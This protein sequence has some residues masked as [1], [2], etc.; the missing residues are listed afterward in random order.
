VKLDPKGEAAESVLRKFSE[1]I[2]SSDYQEDEELRKTGLYQ[3]YIEKYATRDI[4]EQLAVDMKN[5]LEGK[6]DKSVVFSKYE[7][8]NLPP[9]ARLAVHDFIYGKGRYMRKHKSFLQEVGRGLQVF[10]N[11]SAGILG[12]SAAY[13]SRQDEKKGRTG[14]WDLDWSSPV[15]AI[16]AVGAGFAHVPTAVKENETFAEKIREI[17][18]PSSWRY[19]Y[20]TPIGIGMS[21]F[22]DPSMYLTFGATAGSK[23][24]A[25]NLLAEQ[26][27]RANAE[28]HALIKAGKYGGDLNKLDEAVTD[29]SIARGY[30][31]DLGD[32][33]DQVRV[34]SG[35][36]KQEIRSTGHYMPTGLAPGEK[37]TALVR[38][39]TKQKLGA[40]LLPTNLKGGRG[41]RFAGMEIPGTA[42]LTEG[43]GGAVSK[44]ATK[45]RV[46]NAIGN[47]LIPAWQARHIQG[48]AI[49]SSVLVEMSRFT[50]MK[51]MAAKNIAEEVRGLHKVSM[52]EKLIDEPYALKMAEDGT[53]TFSEHKGTEMVVA[54][55][56]EERLGL[57]KADVESVTGPLKV[58]RGRINEEAE[59]ALEEAGKY[60]A[61][62]GR[63]ATTWEGIAKHYDDP[64]EALFDFKLRA[65]TEGLTAEYTN[66]ML[67]DTRFAL[68]LADTK[69]ALAKATAERDEAL[70]ALDKLPGQGKEFYVAARAEIHGAYEVA[71]KAAKE[72]VEGGLEQVPV[73]FT[74]YK[75]G[76]KA[77]AVRD[78][79]AQGLREINNPNIQA[80]STR[81][82]FKTLEQLNR[83]QVLWKKYATSPN[84]AFHV[85]NVLGAMWNNALAGVY[86]PLNYVDATALVYRAKKEEAAQLG[87]KFGM[88]GRGVPESTP[89]GKAAL[90]EFQEA[91]TRGATGSTS[92]IASDQTYSEFDREITKE[93]K[94]IG[95]PTAQG[96]LAKSV[97]PPP[98]MSKK[99]F[100][101][102]R[103][104]QSAATA[105]LLPGGIAA[106]IGL[107]LMAPEAAKVGRKW[108]QLM[109]DVVRIAPFQQASK[110]VA[111][112]RA[113]HTFGPIHVDDMEYSRFSRTEQEI[114]YDI[115]AGVSKHFQFDYSDLTPFERWVAKTVFPFWTFFKK[116]F[117]LQFSELAQEP[118]KVGT[119]LKVMNFLDEN[120]GEDIGPYK[121]ILPQY[122]DELGAFQI[123]V[124]DWARKKLGLPA[125][126][127]LYLNPK[128][129]FIQLNLMPNLWDIFRDDNM[130]FPQKV[131]D[132]I[133]T[134]SGMVGPF[135]PVAFPFGSKMLL[136]AGTGY[137]LG[138]NSPIDY[139]GVQSAGLRQST[140][141]APGWAQY[142]PQP[143]KDHFGIFKS[144]KTGNWRCGATAAYIMNT[145]SMPFINNAGKTI[146]QPGGTLE[147]QG[148]ARADM[149]SWLTGIRLMPVDTLRLSRNEAY[150]ILNVLNA[151]KGELKERGKELSF[152]DQNTMI[153]V[154]AWLDV[155]NGAYDK[156]EGF[157]Q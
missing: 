105:A 139:Q 64:L 83:P 111:V 5:V 122:F 25:V 48:D 54:I 109:E 148:K 118:R 126:Q 138:L 92:F 106:P 97:T 17:N 3:M 32:A 93:L 87:N 143:L 34:Q 26:S 23:I 4:R 141:E 151:K 98:G 49:R 88:I 99:R 70:A 110:D 67:A 33:M 150:T 72:G 36:V 147:S 37:S 149:V 53:V 8:K 94:D 79:V 10:E 62:K 129:P 77:Y 44:A 52:G 112:R 95:K 28:A 45:T 27:L 41:I 155:I 136:E 65:Y 75:H 21:I 130:S 128:L 134:P 81:R 80:A 56:P 152:K 59:A 20:A 116:N 137:N 57:L 114:M 43:I 47:A 140:T 71:E 132:V 89:E 29:V 12:E 121:A 144:P 63:L 157:G 35:F 101:L 96:K 120:S 16:K 100:A 123:P 124:P 91:E 1:P 154:G 38:A 6:A 55:K 142:L 84:P 24:T 104:R 19:K 146:G 31:F 153:E 40:R 46:G 14:T 50:S 60:G 127:P 115:G 61:D 125:D 133:S 145:M 103:A 2:L 117:A 156:R 22:Y 13:M 69:G 85:M 131:R 58:L 15:D 42:K 7:R 135:S 51:K 86:N 113:L 107:I 82:F 74:K 90:R 108:G 9:E 30:A 18:D 66:R 102:K 11:V 119:A 39:T 73:G 78:V 68:P 76:G